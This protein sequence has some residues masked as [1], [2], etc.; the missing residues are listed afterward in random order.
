MTS[1]DSQMNPPDVALSAKSQI[2]RRFLMCDGV[3]SVGLRW[4]DD[5]GWRVVVTLQH[6]TRPP[7]DLPR[8]IDGFAI[9]TRE[10]GPITPFH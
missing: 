9:E 10:D 8:E 2:S 1:N 7:S 5:G 6:G 4:A 3:E